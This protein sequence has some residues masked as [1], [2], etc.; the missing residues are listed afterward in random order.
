MSYGFRSGSSPL[1]TDT[2]WVRWAKILV[3]YQSVTGAD[4][5]NNLKQT[6]SLRQIKV[7]LL[8]SIIGRSSESPPAFS[9]QVPAV[10]YEGENALATNLDYPT[11][12]A[13]SPTISSWQG[14]VS[15]S[16]A[17]DPSSN[18]GSWVSVDVT[19]GQADFATFDN[20]IPATRY[21][22][23]RVRIGGVWSPWAKSQNI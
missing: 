22:A 14:Y 4:S 19:D 6:N 11:H 8:N 5:R 17:G 23:F 7:K 12:P 1:R 10:S 3:H 16:G 18:P 21:G 20:A 9:P 2:R 15:T 13:D